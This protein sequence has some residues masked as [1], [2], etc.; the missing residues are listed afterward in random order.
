MEKMRSYNEFAEVYDLFME[1]VDYKAWSRYVKEIFDLYVIKPGRILDTA[2]GTGNITIPLS[3][4]GYE[5]WGLDLSGDMLSIAESKARASKQKIRFLNQDMIQMNLKEKFDA[6]LCMCDG[7]NYI[8]DEKGLSDY[9]SA[10]YKILNKKGIFIFDISSYN[11][12]RNILG[13]N[14]FHEEKNNKHYIW[15]NNFDESSDTVEMDLIFFVPQGSLY[16][17][18]EEHH[19]QKAHK[20]EQLLMLLEKAGFENIRIFE[21]FSFNKPT[22]YSDRIFFSAIKDKE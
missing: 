6:V 14:T 16:R 19:V 21:E 15:N 2:C 5:L 13:N 22:D 7:V 3:L 8:H 11:K 9:F 4:L 18:F 17:K 1:D 20:C 12:I 10:V